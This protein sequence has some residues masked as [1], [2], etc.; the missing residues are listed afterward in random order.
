MPVLLGV[1]ASFSATL[2][3]SPSTV[4]ASLSRSLES[5][6]LSSSACSPAR[7]ISSSLDSS[8][9]LSRLLPR[10]LP[11]ASSSSSWRASRAVRRSSSAC[12]ASATAL[13]TDE[14]SRSASSCSLSVA[15]DCA[16]R[17]STSTAIRALKSGSRD[18]GGCSP[19]QSCHHSQPDRP[20]APSASSIASQAMPPPALLDAF[21][22]APWADEAGS[23]ACS[24]K[25]PAGSGSRSSGFWV[26]SCS[27]MSCPLTGL[28]Q[29]Y[30]QFYTAKAGFHLQMLQLLEHEVIGGT[31]G[32]NAVRAAKLDR[33]GGNAL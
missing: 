7:E 1:A 21:G 23:E 2:D 10:Y 8:S 30:S 12:A 24:G 19:R 4:E 29:R 6:R 15:A 9:A 16:R 32:H 33:A 5:L 3:S 31:G 22:A 26:S 17:S 13:S 25:S 11:A 14:P 28:P 27:S 20:A 18:C